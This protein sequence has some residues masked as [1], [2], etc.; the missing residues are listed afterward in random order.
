LTDQLH[1]TAPEERPE[2]HIS[3]AEPSKPNL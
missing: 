3:F 2:T 1:Q